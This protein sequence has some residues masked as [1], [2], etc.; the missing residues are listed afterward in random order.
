MSELKKINIDFQ[1]ITSNDPKIL[2]IADF[3]EWSHI[4]N[5]PAVISIKMPGSSESIQ[6]N[7]VKNNIN[8]FNSNTLGIT[9]DVG[10]NDPDYIDLPD[11]IYEICLEA[12]PNTFN[13][14]RYYLK[15]D[16][17]KLELAKQFVKLGFK[18]SKLDEKLVQTRQYLEDIDFYLTLATSSTLLEEIPE[19]SSY[20]HEAI[21]MLEKYKECK[22]CF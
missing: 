12:S 16:A 4:E 5:Q 3:S 11:G 14:F 15:L 6:Y 13:K 20:F 21:K 1:C 22:N 18:Y 7:F 19:A 8:G 9:C 10:C 2:M 17:T